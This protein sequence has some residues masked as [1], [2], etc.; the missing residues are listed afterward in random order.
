MIDIIE[1]L[2]REISNHEKI[3]NSVLGKS[4]VWKNNHYE[5]LSNIINDTLSIK[6][7]QSSDNFYTL[8]NT[9]SQITL[10]R[11][12]EGNVK[13]SAYNDLRF[14]KTLD[15]LAIF[16]GFQD[17]NHFIAEF[18]KNE[19]NHENIYEIT[20]RDFKNYKDMILKCCQGEF[21]NMR[22]L[23]N[24][25]MSV[26]E[27]VVVKNS[28]Y[29]NRLNVYLSKLKNEGIVMVKEISNF[30][31]YNYRF[32]SIEGNM[33]V[34]TTDEFWNLVFTKNDAHFPFHKKGEQ[35]YYIK[36]IDNA[37]KI[38]DNYNPDYQDIINPK[39]P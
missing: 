37:W 4:E 24:L 6:I 17:L 2:K 22:N 9:I 32:V 5:A 26:F 21:N 39:K 27:D 34:I 35:T 11:L 18:Q 31:I 13:E 12:F 3:R 25:D 38:W 10:K 28:P 14:L 15:K 33:I 8:G 29:E 30:E 23:P 16:L 20:E 36:N 19:N 1:G 7:E